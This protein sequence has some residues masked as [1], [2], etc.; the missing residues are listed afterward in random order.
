MNCSVKHSNYMLIITLFITMFLL[1]SC[2]KMGIG[3]DYYLNTDK[4]RELKSPKD[5]IFPIQRGDYDIPVIKKSNNKLKKQPVLYPPIQPLKIIDGFYTS[6]I[7]NKGLLFINNRNIDITWSHL[8]DIIKYYNI[9]VLSKNKLLYKI[10]TDWIN[11]P[12]DYGNKHYI[13]KYQF[14]LKKYHSK[15]Q[16][17]VHLMELKQDKKNIT[18][19]FYIRHYT[20]QM[21]NKIILHW[22]KTYNNKHINYSAKTQI[23]NIFEKN[24]IYA[25]KIIAFFDMGWQRL[26]IA[27]KFIEM[28]IHY[29]Q[30]KWS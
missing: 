13:G 25:S 1:S 27:L 24:K 6:F 7:N 4:L 11:L 29:Y 14:I 21:I 19:S 20:I 18:S 16:L 30:N 15:L 3:E 17:T 2:S 8:I 23:K 28:K 12:K 26:K 5:T 9:P 22:S 10:T